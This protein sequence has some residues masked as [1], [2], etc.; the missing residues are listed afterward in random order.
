MMLAMLFVLFAA[1]D[2]VII[3]AKEIE[4]KL[5]TPPARLVNTSSYAV[6]TM[7]RTA[8]GQAE[9]HEKETDVFYIVDGAATLTTG[10]TM[11]DAKVTEPGEKRGTLIKDGKAQRVAKGDVVTIAKGVP[12][13]FS[14]V[15]KSVTYFVVKVK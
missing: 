13:M 14:A 12:H 4:A 5:K 7:V 3:P 9:L 11:P 2:V 10:G 8:P 15:E 6:Q 1:D